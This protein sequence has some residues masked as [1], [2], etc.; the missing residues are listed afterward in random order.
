MNKF[1]L[2]IGKLLGA[3]MLIAGSAAFATVP[4]H[5]SAAKPS[6]KIQSSKHT[7]VIPTEKTLVKLTLADMGEQTPIRLVGADVAS[8]TLGFSFHTNDVVNIVRLKLKY[9]YSP[10][11]NSETSFLKINLNNQEI[12]SIP[13]LKSGARE[14]LNEIEIDPLLL[15]EWNKLSFHFVSHVDKPFCDD[16]RNPQLWLSISNK[17]TFVEAD[18]VT[19]PVINDLSLFPVPFFDKHDIRD[20]TLPFIFAQKPSWAT[21]QSAGVMASW[22]GTQVEWRKVRFPTH[23][24]NLP[25][26]DAILLATSQEHIDG[27][28]LPSVDEGVATI[29]MVNNPLH[30]S[31]HILLI[32][33]KDGEALIQAARTLTQGKVALTGARQSIY[34]SPLNKRTANDAPNWLQGTKT[35]RIG[36]FVP[37]DKLQAKGLFVTPYDMVLNLPPDIY[38]SESAPIPFDFKFKSSNNSRYLV[39]LEVYFNGK[40]FQHQTFD[41]P[42][43][44]SPMV[45]HRISINIPTKEFT[46]RDSIRVKFIFTD[47]T[48]DICNTAFV[49]DEIKVDP[50][51]TLDI[52][53]IPRYF[54]MP[55]ISYLAYSGYPFSK[56]ADLSET[57]ALLPNDPDQHEIES[58]LML[59]G[60][61]GNKTG[62]PATAFSLGSIQD[63]KKYN[64]KDILILGAV[65]HLRTLTSSWAGDLPA[66]PEALT[67][68]F[69]HPSN[70]YFQRIYRWPDMS[71]RLKAI[72]GKQGMLLMGLQSPL[73]SGRTAVLFT[74]KTSSS[75]PDAVSVLN[76]FQEAKGF[77][78]DVVSISENAKY[79]RATA[80]QTLP[81][82]AIGVLTIP[83]FLN[84]IVHHN[85][86]VALVF[87]LLMAFIFALFSYRKLKQV[88][89]EKLR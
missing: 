36:D 76:T 83:V 16:P 35:I 68:N 32:V 85:P 33:G 42:K 47:K 88:S 21:L 8:S 12:R 53:N 10:T 64:E 18:A 63:V 73:Q 34:A 62:Y 6:A 71:A 81:K 79:D 40:A 2:N 17:D 4:E 82:Y 77:V 27:I 11:L 38:R 28:G 7:T 30:P 13:L 50:G 26:H 67:I 69:P 37:A 86:W 15:N 75:I 66:D 89:Q 70:D 3:L 60:H 48:H 41:V 22:F 84:E 44:S 58:M 29:M 74:A 23:L 65:D 56:F 59:L 54:Q 49:T 55:D 20:L 1:Y 24:N 57:V 9:S 45:E 80:F 46:G 61:I 51:S 19:L 31:A 14:S 72:S 5:A 43:D 78:G 25:D 39:R 87:A 52:S